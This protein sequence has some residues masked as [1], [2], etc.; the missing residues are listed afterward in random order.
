MAVLA[1]LQSQVATQIQQV[2]GPLPGMVTPT[3]LDQSLL[4]PQIHSIQ[5]TQLPQSPLLLGSN[6]P[7]TPNELQSSASIHFFNGMQKPA[8]AQP[9]SLPVVSNAFSQKPS[10]QPSVGHSD[11]Q[12]QIQGGIGVQQHL[13]GNNLADQSH[14]H[15]NELQNS[16]LMRALGQHAQQVNA[17]HPPDDE[18]RQTSIV[19]ATPQAS[20]Q[21]PRPTDQSPNANGGEQQPEDFKEAERQEAKPSSSSS[22][23]VFNPDPDFLAKINANIRANN[24]KIA[25]QPTGPPGMG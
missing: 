15:M 16:E 2:Q 10:N 3:Q 11:F 24:E 17:N 6:F 21:S 8:Y 9:S 25:E 23:F 19:Q 22:E 20:L 18:E 12:V 1:Q 4:H 14:S 7:T 5:P 13:V